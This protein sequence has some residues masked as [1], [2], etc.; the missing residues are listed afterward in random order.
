MKLTR[1]QMCSH[2]KTI[3]GGFM[4]THPDNQ[5]I[6]KRSYYCTY[7]AS[8]GHLSEEC[9]SKPPIWARTP[10]Y[11]EQLVPYYD[12]K[13]LHITSLTKLPIPNEIM[14]SPQLIEIGDTASDIKNYLYSI[15]ISTRSKSKE[16]LKRLVFE[17]A[18]HKNIR[19]Q[20]IPISK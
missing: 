15:G 16:K 17:Y 3:L 7:C 19:I 14:E 9:L 8:Y 1:K 6:L 12:L 10:Q 20:F 4:L 13:R 11:V 2:C 18:N 5:C